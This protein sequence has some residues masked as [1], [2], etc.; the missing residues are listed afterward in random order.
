MLMLPGPHDPAHPEPGPALGA[1]QD[2]G[3]VAHVEADVLPGGVQLAAARGTRLG[4]YEPETC[5]QRIKVPTEY[6]TNLLYTFYTFY[7]FSY[8]LL[9]VLIT[10][11]ILY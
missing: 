6:V 8:I 2:D 3:H 5:Q 11:V 1:V 10:T 9:A 7:T 4:T